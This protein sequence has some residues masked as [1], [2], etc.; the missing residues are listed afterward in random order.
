LENNGMC[1]QHC[2]GHPSRRAFTLIELLVVIAIIA[3]LIGLLIPAVQ[4][5]REAAARAQSLNNCKQMVLAVNNISSNTSTG[6]IPP[7]IGPF[8]AGSTTTQPFFV[9][10][11]PYIEQQ[12]LYNTWTTST[13]TPVKTYIAPADP[14]N[15]GTTGAISYSS[16]AVLLN[17]N[18]AVATAPARLPSSFFGRTSS[19]IVVMERTAKCGALWSSGVPT[20]TAP[21]T[22]YLL[23]TAATASTPTSGQSSSFPEFSSPAL[24]KAVVGA[25]GAAT[26]LSTAGCIVGMG[27]GSSRVVTNG[28]ATAAWGWAINPQNPNPQPSGW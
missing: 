22:N 26:A 21:A 15:A 27:D 5:V 20:T 3:I 12:N 24:W 19:T 16:N 10:I 2:K 4:K 11:L 8:P 9:S 28:S 14:N 25:N 6:D 1:I 7:A 18:A 17:G 23:D 13:A